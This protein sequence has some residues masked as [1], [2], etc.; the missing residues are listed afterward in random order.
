MIGAKPP[1]FVVVGKGQEVPLVHAGLTNEVLYPRTKI[2]L[3]MASLDL[4]QACWSSCN[5]QAMMMN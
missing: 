4:I 5:L 1:G 3:C 2:Y